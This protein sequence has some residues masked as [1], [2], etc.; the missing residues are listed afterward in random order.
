M[1]IHIAGHGD[2]HSARI[3]TAD[4]PVKADGTFSISDSLQLDDPG[5]FWEVHVVHQRGIAC[6]GFQTQR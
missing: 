6:L 2:T 3:D 4:Y 5:M 1:Q